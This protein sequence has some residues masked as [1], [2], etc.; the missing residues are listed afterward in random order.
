MSK[1]LHSNQKDIQF[2]SKVFDNLI[3]GVVVADKD[4]NFIVFNQIA[5][6]ILGFGSVDVPPREWISIY[7]C[8][9]SDMKTQYKVE[10]LPLVQAIN[11][12]QVLNEVMFIRNA[13]QSRGVWINISANPIRDDQGELIA[14]VIVFRDITHHVLAL[15][16]LPNGETESFGKVDPKQNLGLSPDYEN[17]LEFG[18]RYNLLANAVQETEDSILITDSRGT[19][20]YVNSGFEKT[21]GYTRSEAI[22]NTPSILK[23]GHHDR[24]FYDRLWSKIKHGEHFR[25]TILN[26]KKNGDL[27]WSEQTI[28]PIKNNLGKITNYVSVLKDITD[29]IERQKLEHEIELAAEIQLNLIPKSLPSIAGFNIGARLKPARTVSGDF[30]D[31]IQLTEHKIGILIGD[32][33]DKGMAAAILMARVHA[34]IASGAS[35]IEDPEA[36]LLEVNTQLTHFKSSLQFTTVLYGVLD[37]QTKEFSYARAG[38]IPPLLIASDGKIKSLDHT[39]GIGLGLFQDIEL[40]TQKIKMEPGTS[41]L[42][43]TDGVLDSQDIHGKFFGFEGIFDSLKNCGGISSQEICDRLI[44]S[45]EKYQQN[46]QQYDDI[47]VVSFQAEGKL[48]NSGF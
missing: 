45:L 39:L 3:E 42:I 4:G 35:R 18:S 46:G 40:D 38:H 12:V 43:F 32:V 2:L 21:T 27:Y 29:L 9:K 17:Y 5:E 23:S 25:G 14:G 34:L 33:V 24:E 44:D 22:G 10:E 7:G 6:K 20:I 19:I 37:N 48:H 47:A 36:L 28:T 15:D 8:Y 31:I 41:L 26:R 30:F 16:N 1:P 11:G 13:A